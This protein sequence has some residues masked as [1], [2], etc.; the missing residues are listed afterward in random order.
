MTLGLGRDEKV[1]RFR[2]FDA[3]SSATTVETTHSACRET[4]TCAEAGR[5]SRTT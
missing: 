1:L 4:R 2:L 5:S 3:S